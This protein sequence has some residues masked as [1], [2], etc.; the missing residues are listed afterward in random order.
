MPGDFRFPR[1]VKG[2]W[3]I[4]GF[5]FAENPR[6]TVERWASDL[7]R[8]WMRLRAARGVGPS[9]LGPAMMPRSGGLLDQPALMIEAFEMFDLWLEET[10]RDET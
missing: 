1:H 8:T 7:V 9:G 3:E 5:A 2:G 10:R 4:G 6:F